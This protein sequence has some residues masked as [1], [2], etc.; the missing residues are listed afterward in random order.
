MSRVLSLSASSCQDLE[1]LACVGRLSFDA[2]L[3][4]WVLWKE[5]LSTCSPACMLAVLIAALECCVQNNSRALASEEAVLRSSLARLNDWIVSRKKEE[6]DSIYREGVRLKD[7]ALGAGFPA[8]HLRRSFFQAMKI[9]QIAMG[10]I[11]RQSSSGGYL[12]S[13]VPSQSSVLAY[14]CFAE[15]CLHVSFVYRHEEDAHAMIMNSAREW[16]AG[17]IFSLER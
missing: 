4:L 2:Q 3:D 6:V 10:Y 7:G 11:E 13:S 17:K 12:D 9:P 15:S 8:N 5:K 14:E 1:L 16:V